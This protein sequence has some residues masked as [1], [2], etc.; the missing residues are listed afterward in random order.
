MPFDGVIYPLE[1]AHTEAAVSLFRR[2]FP[3]AEVNL[4]HH[5][6]ARRTPLSG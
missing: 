6:R 4:T 3:P 2:A 5:G 1:A